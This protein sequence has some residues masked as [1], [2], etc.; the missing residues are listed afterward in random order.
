MTRTARSSAPASSRA[1]SRARVGIG[2]GLRL[3]ARR[4]AGGGEL[5]GGMTAGAGAA[6]PLEPC[7]R[8]LGADDG[9]A[10]ACERGG[11]LG[12][13]LVGERREHRYRRPVTGQLRQRLDHRPD[14]LRVVGGVEDQR[15]LAVANLEPGRQSERVG[16]PLHRIR[17]GGSS[18]ER[19]RRPRARPRSCA[20]GTRR[21]LTPAPRARRR[22][23]RSASPRARWRSARRAAITASLTLPTTR[24][25]WSLS[26]SELLGRDLL[27]RVAEEV[28]VLE[29]D[30]GQHRDPRGDHVG[31][32]EP[33][34]E[35][36][37]DD[38]DLHPRLG[39]RLEGRG[40]RRLELGHPLA[41][42]S[43]VRSATTAASRV[44]ATARSKA[45]RSISRPPM[46][47]RSDQRSKWGER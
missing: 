42:G 43:N 10:G 9:R 2:N 45:S 23:P 8:D 47:T 44:R 35:S 3:P 22:E 40:G 24:V 5:R 31:R 11:D 34:A 46:C 17:G 7:R 38:G 4:L 21:P 37:L 26:D 30:R 41:V 32:V 13:R 27:L 14:A 36:R 25:E 33:T 18:G 39:E 15:R 16:D 1:R 29:R 20:A 19:L 12:E 28:G 6:D